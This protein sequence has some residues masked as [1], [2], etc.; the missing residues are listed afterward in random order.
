M[1]IILTI[2][3]S[4]AASHSWGPIDPIGAIIIAIWTG[5]SWGSTCM[6]NHAY[7]LCIY[8]YIHYINARIILYVVFR[9]AIILLY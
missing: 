7:W 1:I 9:L 3:F 6:G 5:W 4:V 2:S 8:V